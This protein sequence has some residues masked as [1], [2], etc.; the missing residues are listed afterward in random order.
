MSCSGE[1]KKSDALL[2]ALACGATVAGAAAKAGISERT[3][4]RRL[5]GP[6][7]RAKLNDVRADMVQRAAGMLTAV[8]LEAVKTLAELLHPS[9][10]ASARL[11]ASKVILDMGL[12]LREVTD[13]EERLRLLEK[14]VPA[15]MESGAGPPNAGDLEAHLKQYADV[16]EEAAEPGTSVTTP[17]ALNSSETREKAEETDHE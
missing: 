4:Y 10:P 12:R 6:E 17:E 16:F 3:V 14:R 8:S 2:M 15:D 13:L 7:F 1:N 9:Q 11:R 5:A